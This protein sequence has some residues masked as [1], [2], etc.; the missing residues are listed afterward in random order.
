MEMYQ[1][2]AR[3]QESVAVIQIPNTG[4]AQQQ[5]LAQDQKEGPQEVAEVYNAVADDTEPDSVRT[6]NSELKR[7]A[8][9]QHAMKI[10][11]SIPLI[12]LA[13]QNIPSGSP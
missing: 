6:A 2:L 8:T 1:E 11:D 4:P 9:L 3:P 7:P 12:R 10:Q 13:V 5:Q